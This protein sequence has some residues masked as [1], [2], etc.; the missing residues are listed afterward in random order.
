MRAQLSRAR[1]PG[2]QDG[3]LPLHRAAAN[4]ASVEVVEALL[5]AYPEAAQQKANV[6][7]PSP[8]CRVGCGLLGWRLALVG[9]RPRLRAHARAGVWC[10]VWRAA[11]WRLVRDGVGGRLRVAL[12]RRGR[13]VPS[14][15][16][17]ACRDRRMATY[18]WTSLVVRK[19]PRR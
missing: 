17:H 3:S 14:S 19:L 5:G 18:R 15:P 2:S 1:L 8:T 6:S 16:V 7:A 13:C 4:E 11:V 12:A 10:G 9:G